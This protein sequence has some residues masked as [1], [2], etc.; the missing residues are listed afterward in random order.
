MP[1]AADCEVPTQDRFG[2]RERVPRVWAELRARKS[3][4]RI[5][6]SHPHQ[7]S[8]RA[9]FC[10]PLGTLLYVAFRGARAYAFA[11]T[12]TKNHLL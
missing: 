1:G 2:L 11:S 9:T 4:R 3:T 5:A 12:N 6:A 7:G 8:Q 10:P